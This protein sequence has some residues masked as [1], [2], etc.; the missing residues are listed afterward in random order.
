MLP[1]Q[2]E[3]FIILL[4]HAIVPKMHLFCSEQVKCPLITS[5]DEIIK[6]A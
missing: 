1:S 4:C 6:V 3:I 2:T 5:L